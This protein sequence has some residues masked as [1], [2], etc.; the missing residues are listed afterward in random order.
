MTDI[1]I[2]QHINNL[3]ILEN[4][5]GAKIN[6]R[7]HEAPFLL[8]QS[9]IIS[10][11]SVAKKLAECIGLNSL[12]FIVSI[13]KQKE[14]VGGHIELRSNQRE[15]FIEISENVLEYK[16][17]VLATLAH[18][19]THKYLQINGISLPD[20]KMNEIL[21]DTASVYLGFGRIMLNGCENYTIRHE[22]YWNS[23]KTITETLKTGY[24]NREQF[25]FVYKLICSMRNI[26]SKE[27][28][29]RLSREAMQALGDVTRRYNEYFNAKL[30]SKD[31]LK[32]L[33]E[34]LLIEVRKLQHL[35]SNIEK[36]AI[37][38]QQG[39]ISTIEN[40]LLDMHRN[41]YKTIGDSESMI[42]SECY[43]PCL[44][45][46]NAVLSK[47]EIVKRKTEI[48]KC[49]SQA[50]LFQKFTRKLEKA[51]KNSSLFPKPSLN[52][53][54][55]ITCWNDLTKLRLPVNTKKIIAKCPK[56][57]YQFAADTTTNPIKVCI[58]KKVREM[59]KALIKKIRSFYR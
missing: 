3:L 19:I 38:V 16:D 44:D 35:L 45:Y 42:S 17:S 53:F 4:Q 15:V 32:T 5:I 29:G 58:K 43:N 22:K 47:E 57:N 8:D 36:N 2:S 7:I 37:Y 25:A 21:T 26:P 30:N 55:T 34:D 12:T 13:T 24:L 56:C 59:F 1:P 28:K 48:K 46:L 40:F 50:K 11:Q 49:I 23:E 41:L 9:D 54:N 27:Y 20:E 18:E 51:I 39:G 52:M 14:N 33:I 10:L 6:F 31:T